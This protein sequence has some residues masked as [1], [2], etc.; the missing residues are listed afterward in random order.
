MG[1]SSYLKVKA[2][3]DESVYPKAESHLDIHL[4]T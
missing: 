3:L 1:C 4:V 2:N